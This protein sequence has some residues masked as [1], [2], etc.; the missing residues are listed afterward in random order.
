M[1]GKAKSGKKASQQLRHAPLGNEMEKPAGK[2]RPPKR[3]SVDKDDD[4]NYDEE[5][6]ALES[7]IVSQARE[8]REE[9]Q[10]ESGDKSNTHKSSQW[11]TEHSDSENEEVC[12]VFA[13]RCAWILYNTFACP[14]FSI[15]MM[16]ATKMRTVGMMM[17]W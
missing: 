11:L 3:Q 6:D 7:K 15:L 8:Q 4:D 2:L 17:G 16:R 14:I 10:N 5:Q 12:A 1:S 9:L 13:C